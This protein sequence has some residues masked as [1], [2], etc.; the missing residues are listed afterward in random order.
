MKINQCNPLYEQTQRQNHMV[1]LLDA[2]KHLTKFTP[3]HDKKSWK[4]QEFKAHT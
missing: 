4:D 2:E 3:I 1:I